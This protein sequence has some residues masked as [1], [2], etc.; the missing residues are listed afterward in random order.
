[1]L[2]KVKVTT[3]VFFFF[4]SFQLQKIS[5]VK[6]MNKRVLLLF[7]SFHQKRE[8]TLISKIYKQPYDF[9]HEIYA[10]QW[11][12]LGFRVIRLRRSALESPVV[13]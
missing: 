3:A 2:E 4:T 5:V 13:C 1:M 12:G 9:S 10:F 6:N 7:F 11:L 8:I